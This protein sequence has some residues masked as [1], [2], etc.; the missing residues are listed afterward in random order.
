M[1]EDHFH[2]HGPHDHE[3]EHAAHSRRS[4]RRPHRG[5]DRDLR[6]DRRAVRLHGGRDAERRAA[7][8]ERS[9][10]QE[11]RGVRPVEL[12]PGEEQQAEPRRARR[13]AHDRRA[14]GAIREGGRALQEGEGRR[15]WST[16][17]KLEEA[18]KAAE[19]KS[20]AAMHVHHR[21]AQ[22]MTL[23]QIAIALAAITIL[24]RNKAMGIGGVGVARRVDRARRARVRAPVGA[25]AASAPAVASRHDASDAPAGGLHAR[26]RSSRSATE[27]IDASARGRRAQLGQQLP[28]ALDGAR[29][30]LLPG[31]E[32]FVARGD[33]RRR[34]SAPRRRSSAAAPTG[35]RASRSARA[36]ASARRRAAARSS[37]GATAARARV[38][39]LEIDLGDEL[40]RTLRRAGDFDD[41]ERRVER[42]ERDHARA[43]APRARPCRRTRRP[44][45]RRARA[46]V[47][48]EQRRAGAPPAPRRAARSGRSSPPCP[49]P[50]AASAGTTSCRARA[51]GSCRSASPTAAR[52]RRG[53]RA[54]RSP[55]TARRSRRSRARADRRGRSRAGCAPVVSG[56]RWTNVLP[57]R[58]SM[59]LVTCVAM[60]SRFSGWRVHVARRSARHSARG[61]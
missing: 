38:D 15:S 22:A 27:S 42:V 56:S 60:I 59:L 61:K 53:C 46:L 39:E 8:Q 29:V 48:V 40:D 17:K 21:W 23:I 54:P 45:R 28:R 41:V 20:E 51:R 3:V 13:D 34:P 2:V 57:T 35:R 36:S 18:S 14:A 12:L 11:D 31:G 47:R 24:T 10:D 30:A 19:E 4:V 49:R 33:V 5:D 16:A 43:R 7:L 26:L 25:Q 58:F 9:G 55:S 44:P 52:R 6:D 37:R 1:S 50:G 32:Q